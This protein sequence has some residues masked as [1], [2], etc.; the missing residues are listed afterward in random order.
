MWVI[1]LLRSDGWVSWGSAAREDL[2]Q[3]MVNVLV[4]VNPNLKW[5]IVYVEPSEVTVRTIRV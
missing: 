4:A 1:K 5:E 2:C 3:D